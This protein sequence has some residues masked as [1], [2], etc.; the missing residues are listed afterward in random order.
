MHGSSQSGHP[1]VSIKAVANFGCMKRTIHI[2]G[3]YT[4]LP[5]RLSLLKKGI[6]KEALCREFEQ[7]VTKG[8]WRGW[9]T[10]QVSQ[11]RSLRGPFTVRTAY[12]DGLQVARGWGYIFRGSA[13]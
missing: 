10:L 5:W 4:E 12:F 8:G 11:F 3:A 7:S 13:P 1:S 6:C 2:I 9:V